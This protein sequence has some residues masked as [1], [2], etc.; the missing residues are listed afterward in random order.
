MLEVRS[1]FSKELGPC[2]DGSRV[3][4]RSLVTIFGYLNKLLRAKL[5][6]GIKFVVPA[7]Y[8][9]WLMEPALRSWPS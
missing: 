5:G 9:G 4:S 8:W 7:S 1:S 6:L 3:R 2:V